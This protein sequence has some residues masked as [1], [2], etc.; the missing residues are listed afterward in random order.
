MS[1]FGSGER[2]I[3][4]KVGTYV[5]WTILSKGALW[6]TRSTVGSFGHS[7]S[8]FP[9]GTYIQAEAGGDLSDRL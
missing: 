1:L 2:R 8:I 9:T 7:V 4:P 3:R 5:A 6:E